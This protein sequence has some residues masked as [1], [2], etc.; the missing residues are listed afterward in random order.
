MRRTR[1]GSADSRWVSNPL[2]GGG[3]QLPHREP[4]V[5]RGKPAVDQDAAAR[6][7]EAPPHGLEQESILKAASA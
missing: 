1:G 2:M 4:A 7:L 5:V 3:H 6:R